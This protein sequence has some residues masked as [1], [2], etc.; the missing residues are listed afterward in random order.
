MSIGHYREGYIPSICGVN[1]QASIIILIGYVNFVLQGSLFLLHSFCR[2]II[3]F[4]RTLRVRE[5]A[6]AKP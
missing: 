6:A 1:R 3:W 2:L 4:S 5:N